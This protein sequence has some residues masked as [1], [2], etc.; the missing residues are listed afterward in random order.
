M[1]SIQIG[2]IEHIAFL[3]SCFFKQEYEIQLKKKRF[4]SLWSGKRLHHFPPN[5]AKNHL[6][7][8][9]FHTK[10]TVL[11]SEQRS[12]AIRLHKN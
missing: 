12:G 6:T 5:T 2:Q 9:I 3:V 10:S 1:L 11:K 4:E 7:N 8:N